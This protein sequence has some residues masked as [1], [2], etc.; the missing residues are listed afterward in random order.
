ML[1]GEREREREKSTALP[2]YAQCQYDAVVTL[3]GLLAFVGGAGVPH[4][5]G[6]TD[7]LHREFRSGVKQ[8]YQHKLMNE[9]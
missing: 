6:N 1:K 8:Q 7:G 5:R 2:L 4:L 9:N 3:K